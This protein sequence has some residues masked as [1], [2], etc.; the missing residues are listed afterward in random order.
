ME[1]EINITLEDWDHEC[2]DGCCT[3]YGTEIS[4]NGEK[5]ENQYAGDSV[6]E[7]LKFVLDKLGIKYKI[8]VK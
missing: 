2:G 4:V 7:S 8:I 6:E 3:M 1:K 5:C